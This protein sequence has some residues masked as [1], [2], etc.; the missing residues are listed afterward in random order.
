MKQTT[1]AGLGQTAAVG[2]GGDLIRGAEHT[3]VLEMFLADPATLSIVRIGGIGGSAEEEAAEFLASEGRRGRAKPTVGFIAGV[4]APPGRRMGHAGAIIS[5]GMGTAGA[6]IEA[7]RMAGNTLAA[8]PAA[9]GTSTSES[10]FHIN[11]LPMTHVPTRHTVRSIRARPRKICC[12]P[13]PLGAA[14]AAAFESFG[15]RLAIGDNSTMRFWS[16]CPPTTM[17]RCQLA[18]TDDSTASWAYSRPRSSGCFLR[19]HAPGAP[20]MERGRHHHS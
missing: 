19:E 16:T 6:K 13:A 1:Y 12:R 3:D 7:M 20:R 14:K 10:P 2:I 5:G 9:L 17:K 18:P 15:F 4:T 11:Y 8:S